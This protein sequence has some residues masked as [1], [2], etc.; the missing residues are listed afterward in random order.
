MKI[1]NFAIFSNIHYFHYLIAGL[2]LIVVASCNQNPETKTPPPP[3]D[4]P[5]PGFNPY[6]DAELTVDVFK[7]DSIESNGS[8]GWGYDILKNGEPII[9]QPHIPAIMGNNGFSSE[10]KALVAGEFVIKKIKN[11]ILPPRV[12]PEELD[13][14]G[15]LD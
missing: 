9:H 10:E 8:R 1:S 5:A 11:N 15:V 3:A 6:Q 13:S 14:L 7:V 12:T 2:V 4:Q